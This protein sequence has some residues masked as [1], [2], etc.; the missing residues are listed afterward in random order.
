MSTP[1]QASSSVSTM[2]R[3]L[4]TPLIV[5]AI[6]AALGLGAA[7]IAP[8][9]VDADRFRPAL[10]KL[11]RQRLGRDVTIGELDVSFLP[12]TVI[13]RGAEIAGTTP[14]APW[15]R[16]R[17]VRVRTSWASL[18]SGELSVQAVAVD[19]P[20]VRILRAP[21]GRF[22]LATLLGERKPDGPA[23][24]L[25]VGEIR[26]RGGTVHVAD[27]FIAPGRVVTT[28]LTNVDAVVRG[29]SRPDG[30][31]VTATA[32]L[33]SGG[34]AGWKGKI[35]PGNNLAGRARMDAVAV[36]PLM[37]Y[38]ASR[39]SVDRLEGAVSCDLEISRSEP[40]TTARGDVSV[41]GLRMSGGPR[42]ARP[43]DAAAAIDVAIASSGRTAIRRF[44]LSSGGTRVS[45]SG[46]VTD[47]PG[48]QVVALEV[49]APRA[50]L[51]EVLALAAA[52]GQDLPVSGLGGDALSFKGSARIVRRG[53]PREVSS[54]ALDGVRVSGLRLALRREPGG[55]WQ[56]A[57]APPA[58]A[59]A[60]PGL[61]IRIRDLAV[62]DAAARLED[63]SVN[64]PAITEIR[65]VR[66]S[67]ASWAP[68]EAGD[69]DISARV[70]SGSLRVH[71]RVAAPG[72]ATAGLPWDARI[73]AS[74]LDVAQAAALASVAGLAPRSGRAS[75]EAR[76][77]GPPGALR[78]A[79]KL[80]MDQVRLALATGSEVVLD[81]PVEH[82]VTLRDPGGVEIHRL[83][84][85]LPSGP[86]EIDGRLSTAGALRYD[87]GTRAPV[88][89][90][91]RDVSWL[92]ALAGARMPI[93]LE[94]GEPMQVDARVRD[95]GRGLEIAGRAVLRRARVRHALL[96]EPLDIASATVALTG[97]SLQVDDASLRLGRSALRGSVALR[98]FSN[99]RLVFDLESPEADLD[100]LFAV[101]SNAR[102]GGSPSRGAPA[103]GG[104]SLAAMRADGRLRVGSATFGGL[105]LSRFDA[106]VALT[107]G[108][109]TF[110]PASVE[111]YGGR[112][113]GSAAL[114]LAATPVRFDAD[115]SLED[116]D[117]RSLLQ[118]G[119]GYGEFS[120]TGRLVARLSGEAGS[121]DGAIRAA[122]GQGTVALRDGVVGR[123]NALKALER[124]SVFGEQS[125]AAL[126]ARLSREGTPYST[127]DGEWTLQDGTLR[128]VKSVL[129]APD[130]EIQSS[131]PVSLVDQRINLDALVVFSK[132]LSDAMRAEGSRAASVFWDA[133]RSQVVL[134]ARLTGTMQAPKAGIDWNESIGRVLERERDAI[135]GRGQGGS[136]GNLGGG[137]GGVGGLLGGLLG[138]GR[139]TAP[140]PPSSAPAP[141]PAEGSAAAPSKAT[142]SSA[143]EG[144]PTVRVDSAK[145]GGSVLTPDLR[146]RLTLSGTD[147]SHAIV[148]VSSPD[149]REIAR[150]DRALES[151]VATFYAAAPRDVAAEIG[152]KVTVK[153]EV[154]RGPGP[155][156]V[157]AQAVTAAGS[158]GEAV[159]A[160]VPRHSPF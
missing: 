146:L 8:A 78:L 80:Q 126:G 145:M 115:M 120:G 62:T 34:R 23:R 10:E 144:G 18:F 105:Q 26:V 47:E 57:G 103:A 33:A 56:L 108:R 68:G 12:P 119:I 49:D 97:D 131:G 150:V 134:P 77:T 139:T 151:D 60:G 55:A 156:V 81:M 135:L 65:D 24:P 14:G 75:W 155:F 149:G 95:A 130:G 16:A 19:E 123:L 112:G 45:T 3:K 94:L 30:M 2:R 121:V 99:P 101:A 53:N 5:V 41:R 21:D 4:R 160:S 58:T 125:L 128:I 50:S 154:L 140:A 27:A 109:L 89:L 113:T 90:D 158:A 39:L 141:A 73:T 59:S 118:A 44:D 157:T 138:G 63:A 67:I 98:D 132:A 152:G 92:L 20:E 61:A 133:R 76:L 69:V 143:F 25:T 83:A 32:H 51:R 46:T 137:S 104:A 71:G 6:L 13:V 11:A 107:D 147:L 106:S 54:V 110:S 127:L 72:G 66:A 93:G 124:A 85:S 29:L 86:V 87:I 42:D 70:A 74:G 102:T 52:A 35:G 142:P 7:W 37:P 122:R 9:L 136:T 148:V 15:L 84:L 88:T 153:F 96:T 100:E 36:E 38:L 114:D 111:L 43:A 117:V 159:T 129:V 17:G 48:E 79:G 116:V 91:S 82:D 64:P 22:N 31:D 28:T 40:G 1:R